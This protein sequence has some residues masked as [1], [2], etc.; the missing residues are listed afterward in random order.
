MAITT[1]QIVCVLHKSLYGAKQ[2]A[3]NFYE[4]ISEILGELGL[5]QSNTDQCIYF[6]DKSERLILVLYV[7]DSLV[8][9]I[10][11]SVILQ[12][13]EKLKKHFEI[14]C[15]PIDCFLGLQIKRTKDMGVVIHQENYIN[16]VLTRFKMQNCKPTA[17]LSNREIFAPDETEELK[18]IPY[19]E[20]IGSIM[21][22]AV[23][24]RPD[25]AFATNYLS[26]HMEKPTKRD[27]NAAMRILSYLKGSSKLGIV[28]EHGADEGFK[29]F[30]DAD[31][32][33]DSSRKSTS[34]CLITGF[35]G[36]I[37]WQ[38]SKQSLIALSS[39]ESEL[40]SSAQCAQELQRFK[41]LLEEIG[42]IE[43]PVL[44]LDNQAV[45]ASVSNHQQN[46]RTKH[47]EIKQFFVREL[48]ES[49]QIK[50]EY[51]P[52]EFMLADLLTKPLTKQG[53]Q[54][55]LSS[56]VLKDHVRWKVELFGFRR[57]SC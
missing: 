32:A 53:F 30:S 49:K 35:G 12:F 13:I 48:V 33:S 52:N 54:R 19:R 14:S 17:V 29:Y 51:I 57:F 38:S 27:W 16:E 18:D 6:G 44:Y 2:S 7:D 50:V 1:T 46:R 11:K 45:I 20:V 23:C 31:F 3:R 47:I 15:K 40:A 42:Y 43:T 34:G 55:L 37:Y 21:Y 8:V 22:I 4:Q 9:G 10:N 36:A 24:T 28:Y 39:F 56:L 5:Q 41:R 25:I 26:R